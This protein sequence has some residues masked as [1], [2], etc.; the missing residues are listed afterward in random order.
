MVR[1]HTAEQK[2]TAG[3]DDDRFEENFCDRN[4]F[5]RPAR[6]CGTA[7]ERGGGRFGV[8]PQELILQEGVFTHSRAGGLT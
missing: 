2:R 5:L 1:V 4:A 8:T 7:Q 6:N 3:R